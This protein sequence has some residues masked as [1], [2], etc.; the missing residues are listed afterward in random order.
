[1]YT[2]L[3][4]ESGVSP[5]SLDYEGIAYVLAVILMVTL[6]L[7]GIKFVIWLIMIPIKAVGI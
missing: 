4:Y 1:M 5:T 7:L 6:V 2:V 3:G